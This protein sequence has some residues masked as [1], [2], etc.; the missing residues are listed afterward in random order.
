VKKLFPFINR[1]FHSFSQKLEHEDYRNFDQI[2][3]M[4]D[5]LESQINEENSQRKEIIF[6]IARSYEEFK[7]AVDKG[8][9]PIAHAIE[10]GHGIGRNLPI[11]AKRQNDSKF[12]KHTMMKGKPPGD[13]SSYTKNLD[14]LKARGLC[15]MTLA[16]FFKNDLVSPVDG[17]SPDGK[18]FP[19][20]AWQY[21]PDKDAPLS[22]I[23]RTVVR[24]M[25]DIGIVVD[26]THTTPMG[27]NEVFKINRE[28]NAERV[29]RGKT[30]RPLVFTYVGAQ[31]IYDMGE[32][33]YYCRY[34]GL[35][36][37]LPFLQSRF[38][39]FL[40]VECKGYHP[41]GRPSSE[42]RV[43]LLFRV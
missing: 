25:L 3:Q 36:T 4:M 31:T 37:S 12:E 5:I 19:G 2:N 18:K 35:K 23:G 33:P 39:E 21:T 26:L 15:M 16:H 30:M 20:M 22:D 10:G 24:H 9:I 7:A 1:F 8:E 11:S 17:V 29:G 14:T 6:V 34:Q 13:Y 43:P 28:M 27:R 42:K 40:R 32:Y 38:M 41:S